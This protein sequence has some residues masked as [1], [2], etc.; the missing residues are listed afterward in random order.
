MP[1]YHIDLY[2]ITGLRECE[3]LNLREYLYS[4]G[5]SLIEWFEHLPAGEVEEYLELTIA[6][7]AGEERKLSFAAYGERY[8]K[9]LRRLR[10]TRDMLISK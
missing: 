3:D 7:G 2:R 5:V 10:A 8:E 4:D 9:L 1:I 6:Y